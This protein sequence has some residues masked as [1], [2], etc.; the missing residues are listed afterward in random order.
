MKSAGNQLKFNF[1]PHRSQCPHK[2]T[3]VTQAYVPCGVSCLDCGELISQ[4]LPTPPEKLGYVSAAWKW[5]YIDGKP[6]TTKD[7]NPHGGYL[8][9]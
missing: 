6:W 2:R 3:F 5:H 9:T 1:K 4:F 7:R 8:Y